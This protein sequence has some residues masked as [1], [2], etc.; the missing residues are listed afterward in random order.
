MLPAAFPTTLPETAPEPV[1]AAAAWAPPEPK[2]AVDFAIA[3]TDFEA[4]AVVPSEALATPVAFVF[5]A[6]IWTAPWAVSSVFA[7]I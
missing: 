5:V 1:E 3:V 7:S 2:A 6:L 4:F